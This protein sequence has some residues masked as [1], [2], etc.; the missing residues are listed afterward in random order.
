MKKEDFIERGWKFSYEFDGEIHFVKGDP[1]KDD[2]L[3][4]Y[5][6]V[7]NNSVKLLT[8]DCGYTTDGPQISIKFNGY[9][10]TIEEFDMICKMIKLKI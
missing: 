9:C 3:G 2:G 5:L 7:K 8:T 6:Y 10:E 4:S 1:W